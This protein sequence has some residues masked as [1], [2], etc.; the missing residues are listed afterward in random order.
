MTA[1]SAGTGT[2]YAGEIDV[3]VSASASQVYDDNIT[4][5]QRDAQSDFVTRL[6]PEV[7]LS[8]ENGRT[9]ASLSADLSHEVYW[10]YSDNDHTSE[11]AK[12][13][14]LHQLSKNDSIRVTD[15]FSHS[16]EPAAFDEQ[17]ARVGGRYSYYKN[18]FDISYFKEFSRDWRFNF[19]YG[20]DVDTTNRADLLDSEVHRVTLGADYIL[21]SRDRV[22][23]K[24]DF[25]HRTLDPGG[26][27]NIHSLSLGE[28]HNFSEKLSIEGFAGVDMIESYNGE[29][30]VKPLWTVMLSN[31]ITDRT[32]ASLSFTQRY[33]TNPYTSDVFNSWRV[34]GEIG[35]QILKKLR[36]SASLFYARGEYDSLDLKDE[37]VGAGVALNYELRKDLTGS[38]SYNYSQSM[39]NVE[40]R[41]YEKNVLSFGISSEF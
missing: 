27:A 33:S 32:S 35:S 12:V 26:D 6:S 21:S 24:Y 23:G 2:L 20:Y 8:Y 38:V 4:Y 9:Q 1:A 31:R 37:F 36:G 40:T 22:L 10:R 15:R 11:H 5:A 34:S 16:Y 25:L 17:L 28:R 19:G 30:I 18:S 3:K 13:D 7:R 41:E 39:S 14:L 29:S